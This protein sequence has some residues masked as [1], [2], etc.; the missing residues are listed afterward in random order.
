MAT[1]KK[2][3]TLGQILK[4]QG[5]PALMERIET[6]DPREFK[7]FIHTD[8]DKPIS[9]LDLL[10]FNVPELYY[11]KDDEG[12]PTKLPE[13][14]VFEFIDWAVKNGASP[15]A[16]IKYG[17]S[18]FLKSAGLPEESL[19][20]YFVENI[21]KIDVLQKDGRGA[22]ILMHAVASQ[23]LEV[24]DYVT[25]LQQFDI[26]RQYTLLNNKTILHVACALGEE[27]MIDKILAAGGDL[28]IMDN[29]G[30]IPAD[31]VP[32]ETESPLSEEETTPEKIQLW[33]NL[34]TKLS[35]LS[36]KAVKDKKSVKVYK[37][38]F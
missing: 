1:A 2:S 28:T 31:M 22:D 14:G 29:A 12:K 11:V 18:A 21:P 24:F 26:N 34:F 19:L 27:P 3:N 20:K 8:S 16:T 38:S 37:T 32:T 30:N 5:Y 7:N 33:E 13:A 25:S 10:L 35:E 6:L 23:S 9:Q 36:E 4:T 15:N 17:N